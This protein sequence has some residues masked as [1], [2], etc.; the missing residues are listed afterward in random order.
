[1]TISAIYLCREVTAYS[2]TRHDIRYAI[3]LI[4]SLKITLHE[5]KR[6]VFIP[7]G[8]RKVPLRDGIQ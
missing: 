5:K 2:I 1:M 8:W 3:H 4:Y 6:F 7:L